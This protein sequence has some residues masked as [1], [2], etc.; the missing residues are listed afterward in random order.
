MLSNNIELLD[1]LSNCS[2]EFGILDDF[3]QTLVNVNIKNTDNTITSTKMKLGDVMYYTEYG[4]LTIPGKF[5]LE[6][7][8]PEVENI[9]EKGISE[10]ID[11]IIEEDQNVNFIK[12]SLNKICLKIEDKVK[13]YI[14]LY[15]KQH[16]TL[17]R[18]IYKDSAQNNYLYDLEALSKYIKCR[19]IFEN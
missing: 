9:L 17:G 5:I 6:K 8:T 16:D 12:D 3:N 7:I 1:Y 19:P 4:T 15:S 18:I 10:I 14:V 11:V 13:N 2:I